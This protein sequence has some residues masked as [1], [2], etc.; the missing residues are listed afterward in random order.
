[1]EPG[2]APASP[3]PRLIL[4]ALSITLA[5]IGTIGAATGA[6]DDDSNDLETATG[7]STTTSLTGDE[8][9]TTSA[10][11]GAATTLTTLKNTPTTKG[12]TATTAGGSSGGS[13][14]AG[15]PVSTPP[16]A[17][18]APP[19]VGSYDYV[20]CGSGEAVGGRTVTAGSGGGGVERRVVQTT[21]AFGDVYAT[22]AFSANGTVQESMEIKSFGYTVACDWKP[23]IVEYPAGLA[24]GK[25][26][27]VNT[28]CTLPTGGKVTVT[29]T[30][31]VTGIVNYVVGGTTVT[32]WVIDETQKQTAQ[33]PQGNVVIDQTGFHY[34]DSAHGLV[35][36]QKATVTASGGMKQPPT[37]V[38]IRLVSL[39]PKTS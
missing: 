28:S 2:V 11:G 27:S 13:Q 34:W 30:R 12:T 35:A 9:T 20:E 26:W 32:A 38:E 33:T 37:T 23:D 14:C 21:T 8:S 25:S 31:K 7:T 1:M 39:T 15:T 4:L 17:V 22:T 5:L 29:G 36:Y 19:T 24:V 3:K 6:A 10:L 18:S 16:A